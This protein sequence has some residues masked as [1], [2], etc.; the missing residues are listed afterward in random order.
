MKAI[1]IK[2]GQRQVSVFEVDEPKPD[3][4]DD[5]LIRIIMAGID[6]TDR[7]IVE[8]GLVEPP[9]GDDFLILG[10]EAV[11]EVLKVGPEVRSLKPGMF[12]VPTVRR[13]CERCPSCWNGPSDMCSTGLFKE[14]GV[15]KLHGYFTEI[16]A[17]TT[18]FKLL[19]ISPVLKSF[20]QESLMT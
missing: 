16:I 3:A 7:A 6:G 10:H 8:N 11:G 9:E 12:V 2:T 17:A 1:G 15:R 13:S 18:F 4:A 20:F 14:R 19:T 5:V